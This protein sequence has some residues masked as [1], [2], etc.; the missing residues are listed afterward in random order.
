M[1]YQVAT[2]FDSYNTM[3]E[4][5]PRK[6]RAHRSFLLLMACAALINSDQNLL[7]PNLSAAAREFGFNDAVKDEKMGGELAMALFLVGAPAALF[8]GAAADRV[9]RRTDLLALVLLIGAV[10]CAGSAAASSFEQL[11][12]A[13][14]LT[15]VSLGGALPISFSFLGDLFAERERVL[16]SSQIGLAMSIGTML[17]QAMSGFLGPSLGWRGQHSKI[18]LTLLAWSRHQR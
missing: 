14:A 6:L 11:W 18:E 12:Y 10:G 7:A 3:A 15:G 16:R 2:S 13:R 17:G 8:V 1:T 5:H 4:V 9:K